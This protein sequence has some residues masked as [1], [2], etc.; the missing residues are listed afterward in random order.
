MQII[1][2]LDLARGRAVLAQAGDRSRYEPVQSVLA[3]DA[4]GDPVALLR[5]FRQRL[6]VNECY[7]AD[8]DAIQGG[9]L[10]RTLIRELAQFETGFSGPL[11]IDAGANRPGGAM[12][13]L[14]CGASEV[15]IGLESLLAFADLA[16]IV[17]QVGPNRVVF[18]LDLRLGMPIMH[19]ALQ[20]ASGTPDPIELASQ[21]VDA[22]VRSLVIL[23]LARVGTG[24]GVELGRLEALRRRF[25]E[26]RLMAG[27]GVLARRDL[28]RMRD[29]GCDGALLASAIHAGR[30]TAGDLSD[31]R[32]TPRRR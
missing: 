23:D 30:I 6:G 15:V 24:C 25:P 29:V 26:I 28:E 19:P 27:G 20:D 5:G 18:S 12:E 13:V 31:F 32:Q 14:S 8:L 22:G 16:A 11:L 9:V 3:P 21:A 17:E 7:I 1:P 4:G 10:Q 2:V